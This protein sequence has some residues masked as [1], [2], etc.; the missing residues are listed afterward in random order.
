MGAGRT[1]KKRWG[2]RRFVKKK[3]FYGKCPW[4]NKLFKNPCG[5]IGVHTMS[6]HREL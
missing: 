6:F 5:V 1:T 2:E 3:S 4:N